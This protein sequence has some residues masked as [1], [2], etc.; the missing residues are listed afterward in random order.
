LFLKLRGIGVRMSRSVVFQS[1]ETIQNGS[2]VGR[3]SS[4]L[5]QAWIPQCPKENTI[6]LAWSPLQQ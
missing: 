1:S 4:T 5:T 6:H 3:R 2:K